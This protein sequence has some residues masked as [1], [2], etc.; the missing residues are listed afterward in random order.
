MVTVK[1]RATLLVATLVCC[2]SLPA[3]SVT[4]RGAVTN[5][6]GAPLSETT[7]FLA[8]DRQVRTAVTDDHG[9][10]RFDDVLVRMME[11]TAYKDGYALDGHTLLPQSDLELNLTLLTPDSITIRV[12]NN[13]FMPIPG[14]RVTAMTVNDRFLV[15]AADLSDAGFPMLRSNDAGILEIPMLPENG[16]I[17]LTLG[18]HQYADSN[19]SYLPVDERQNDIILY[20][21]T[22]LRGRVTAE[23]E[24]VADA[25]VSLFQAGVGGQRRFAEALT[26]P[27][28]YYHLRAPEDTYMI[29]T[30]HPE[31]ASPTPVSV[32][33]RNREETATANLEL[34]APYILRGS[35]LL[36]DGA[37]CPGARVLFRHDAIIFDDTLTDSRGEF[38]LRVGQ[39][40]GVLRVLPPPGY[41]TEILSDIPVALG[42]AQEMRVK[43]V[44]LRSLPV[45]RGR[46]RFPEGVE[47]S[48]V[49]LRSLDLPMPIHDITTEDGAFEIRFAYQPEQ[50]VLT[51]RLEHPLRL[52]RRDFTINL[53]EPGEV[54]LLL[55]PFDPDVARRP[56]ELG[57][58]NL[59]A[60]LGEEAPPIQCSEW[61]NTQPLAMEDLRGKVVILTFWGGFDDSLFGLNRLVELRVMHE[62]FRDQDDVVVVAVHDASSEP[63]EVEEYVHGYD[64]S[65]P[66]GIDDDPFVSFDN[67]GVNFIPQ[68]VLIDKQGIVRYAQVE[69]RLLE[70]VKALRRRP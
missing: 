51:F 50:P 13:S 36:P 35:V 22:R 21:G 18:H 31:Y 54:E 2:I 29:T 17:K 32:D 10:Y 66:V 41:M 38:Q 40:E 64:I 67:Y 59:E 60:L 15:S 61:F 39:P 4:V 57:R 12:I 1:T 43:P 47:P 7:V 56:P 27:E 55:E 62:L 45:I 28:G 69:G 70:L 3:L 26:D 16:F 37:P 34:L 6:E 58:N 68:T 53:E 11:L 63:D 52:L 49:Y 25:R 8:Q 23:E 65:F 33:M 9:R 14:A 19:V 30:W 5:A 44:Q 42:D 48:R 20:E 46:A 24:P